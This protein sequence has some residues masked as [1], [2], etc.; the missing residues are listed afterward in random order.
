[1]R[2]RHRPRAGGRARPASRALAP[3]ALAVLLAA[4]CAGDP[5]T[6]IDR[7]GPEATVQLDTPE[8][9]SARREAGLAPCEDGRGEPGTAADGGLPPLELPCFGSPGSVDL[10]TLRGPLVISLWASWCAPCRRELPVI[11]DFAQ[12]HGDEVAVLGV[13]YAD[14]QTSSAADLLL[15]SGVTFPQLADPGG[16]LAR[17]DPVRV[18]GLPGLVLV[19][20]DGRVVHQEFR[21]LEDRADLEQL[22][23]EH[24]GVRL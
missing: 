21:E 18:P 14:R 12:R 5:Q 22:V 13:D 20:A 17:A 16:E 3:L 11:Q 19:D 9:R 1:M 23:V 10:A 24:L 4:G 15:R 6:A 2:G 7:S 8:L